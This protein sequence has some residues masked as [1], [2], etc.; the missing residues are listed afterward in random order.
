MRQLICRRT[1]EWLEIGYTYRAVRISY[2]VHLAEDAHI[3]IGYC[4]ITTL[5]PRAAAFTSYYFRLAH[6]L[7]VERFCIR[8]YTL[9]IVLYLL[10]CSALLSSLWLSRVCVC[11]CVCL[12]VYSFL[13][14]RASTP[15]NIGAYVFTATRKTLYSYYNRNFC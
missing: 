9:Y 8:T 10:G 11:V 6:V 13:P 7:H 12:F 14:S 1:C 4:K 3:H 5:L 2:L 15:R